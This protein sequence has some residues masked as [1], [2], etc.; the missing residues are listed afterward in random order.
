M[1]YILPEQQKIYTTIDCKVVPF[2]GLVFG[3]IPIDRRKIQK[4]RFLLEL[5]SVL[6][7]LCPEEKYIK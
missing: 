1:E 4:S 7:F 3:T 6:F 5:F 2:T